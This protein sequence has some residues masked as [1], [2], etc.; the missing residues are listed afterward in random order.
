[1]D[2]EK[3]AACSFNCYDHRKNGTRHG[4]GTF[5]TKDGTEWIGDWENDSMSN[6]KSKIKMSRYSL[7]GNDRCQENKMQWKHA[8]YV[9]KVEEAIMHGFGVVHFDNDVKIEAEYNEGQVLTNRGKV[10]LKSQQVE[11]LNLE[12]SRRLGQ[13]T[14]YR[15]SFKTKNGDLFDWDGRNLRRKNEKTPYLEFEELVEALNALGCFEFHIINKAHMV[16]SP[17]FNFYE[18]IQFQ[19]SKDEDFRDL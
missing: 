8:F 19:K 2:M 18:Q 13:K 11:I 7:S 1:M 15:G 10:I 16:V 9:G 3:I 5:L 6:N 4:K 12:S 14:Y 17:P